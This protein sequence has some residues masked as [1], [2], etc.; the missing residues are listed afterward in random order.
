MRTAATS[1]TARITVHSGLSSLTRLWVF[2]QLSGR[3]SGIGCPPWEIEGVGDYL[4]PATPGG[5][6]AT[7]AIAEQTMGPLLLW[8]IR[9]VEE[10][11][12]DILAAWVERSR[13][14]E[15]A[16]ANVATP[17]SRAALRAFMARIDAEELPIPST[18]WLGRTT[19]A[20]VYIAA[21]TG[22]SL[23]QVYNASRDHGWRQ[24]ALARPGPCPLSV[25]ISGLLDGT[26][27]R[28]AI[29]YTEAAFLRRQ[30]GTACFIVIAYLT[31][32]RPGEAAGLRSGCCPDPEPEPE[33]GSAEPQ[34]RHLITSTVYKTARDA[35]GNHRSEGEIR[36]VPWV[37]IAPVV[38][39]I[40]VLE[41]MVPDGQLLFD[42]HAHDLRGTRAGTGSLTV[43]TLGIRVEDFVT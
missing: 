40:R 21:L 34:R 43:H 10:F 20:G 38:N 42:H 28:E 11:S 3:P 8:A 4:P 12:D 30:L 41:R 37:A 9:T 22:A 18:D 33:P 6:N 32:M 19:P 35:D 14:R 16:A 29:D 5:E 39:A 13:L 31:G 1:A 24:A 17:A 36:D 25:P 7:E 2:D 15:A 26:A 27:W 23:N